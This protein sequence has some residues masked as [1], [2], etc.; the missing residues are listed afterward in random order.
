MKHISVQHI[1]DRVDGRL[2]GPGELEIKRVEQIDLAGPDHL[3]FIGTAD[4]AAKWSSSRASAAIVQED[5][6]VKPGTGRAFVR[7]ADADLA[8]A[9]VLEMFAPP[10]VSPPVGVDDR[11]IVDG[12][13]QVAPDVAIGALSY[14]GPNASI[15]AGT[16][17]HPN[18][19]V[20]EGV[21]VGAG[22]VLWP[23]VV[24][25]ERCTLGDGCILHP[26]VSIGADGFGYRPSEDG[27]SLVKIPQIGSVRLG[28]DVEIG[29]G[30]CVD[31]G[32]F[33]ETLIGD[34]TKIDNL[35]QIAHNCNIGRCVVMAALVG[36]GGSVT[37][38]D[39][40]MI[41]G[42]AIIKDHLTIGAGARLGGHAGLM[43]DIPPG[44]TW[45]GNPAQDGRA[46][47][48]EYAAIR[49]L[50]DLFQQIKQLREGK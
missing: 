17:L 6:E 36:I 40:V 43:H 3:T 9:K 35:C 1:C 14:V 26:N 32:K 2:E 37:I 42:G 15:G 10:P 22:C 25:R 19:T 4:Y 41:G 13:A 47:F 45:Q 27:R 23:G 39:G 48:R 49:K 29:A 20:L 8:L 33:A 46:A 38:G 16:I 24:I 18:V 5:I 30:T 44:E 7:V 12:T 50:P 34:G 11:A 31:R 21:R 28:R